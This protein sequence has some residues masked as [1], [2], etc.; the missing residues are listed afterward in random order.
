MERLDEIKALQLDALPREKLSDLSV[1]CRHLRKNKNLEAKRILG[2]LLSHSLPPPVRSIV[3]SLNKAASGYLHI[4]AAEDEVV[5]A[6]DR[7]QAA[8]GN[9]YKVKQAIDLV[10]VYEQH[11][12]ELAKQQWK[13]EQQR[14]REQ[15]ALAQAQRDE[16]ERQAE[17][18]RKAKQQEIESLLCFTER[19]IRIHWQKSDSALSSLLGDHF[20]PSEVQETRKKLATEWLSA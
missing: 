11:M 6:A 5:H 2:K 19:G 10:L 20:P 1:A 17:L 7:T 13:D 8:L 16:E 14:L 9:S 18:A 12:V 3:D 4:I 15:E